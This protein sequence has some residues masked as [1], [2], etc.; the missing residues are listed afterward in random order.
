MTTLSPAAAYQKHLELLAAARASAAAVVAAVG[1]R[2]LDVRGDHA[3]LCGER[4]RLDAAAHGMTD[5]RPLYYRTGSRE[6]T[7]Y[8]AWLGE[9]D[10]EAARLAAEAPKAAPAP[11]ALGPVA[12]PPAA[13]ANDTTEPPPPAFAAGQIVEA[14]DAARR[15]YRPGRVDYVFRSEV[16]GELSY[17]VEY[18]DAGPP[19][20]VVAAWLRETQ[21]RPAPAAPWPGRD[22]YPAFAAAE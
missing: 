11:L 8:R 12:L 21:I 5:L 22:D 1:G 6:E 3:L 13:P 15:A 9:F 10:A 2:Y 19:P 14:Y 20:G 7:T 18:L 17:R 4:W 16:S